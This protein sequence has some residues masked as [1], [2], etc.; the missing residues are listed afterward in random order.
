ML[1]LTMS[2]V[3][4]IRLLVGF[5]INLFRTKV[6]FILE[7][8][9]LNNYLKMGLIGITHEYYCFQILTE[10]KYV[11]WLLCTLQKL[12]LKLNVFKFEFVVCTTPSL[13]SRMHFQ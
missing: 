10:Y 2:F 8:D 3:I 13:C 6:V 4:T 11:H 1:N 7:L 5:L 9:C 12:P